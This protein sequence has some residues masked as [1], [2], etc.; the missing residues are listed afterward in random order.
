MKNRIAVSYH[1][2]TLGSIATSVI[3]AASFLVNAHAQTPKVQSRLELRSSDRQLVTAFNWAKQ[4]ALAYVHNG[5]PVGPWYEAA[6]PGRQAFCMR[7]VSH[8][9]A[10]AQA[11]GFAGYTHNMLRRFAENISSSRDW[12][13][14][15]EIDRLNRPAPIDYVNDDVFWY[16]LPANFDV[17]DACYRMYLW[18]GDTSYIDD[19][20]FLSFYRHT[21]TDYVSRWNLDLAHVMTRETVLRDTSYFRGDPSYAE[22]R[23]D[24][25]LG[26]DLLAAQYAGYRSYAAIAAIRG[27]A[28]TTKEYE[29][30]AADVKFLIN[31]KGWNPST[32]D[33]HGFLDNKHQF[34]GQAGA[35]LLYWDA[36]DDGLKARSA[37]D[38]LLKTMRA[39]PASAVEPES[40][41]AEILYRYGEPD[42][43]YAEIMDLTRTGR[44]RREYPE[45]SFS[46][47]GAIVNG[48]MGINVEPAVPIDSAAQSKHFETVISTLPQL[49][50][51]TAWA[52]LRNL[53]IGN[54]AIT[55]RHDGERRTTLINKGET[56]LN[57]EPAF[58]GAFASLVVNG[59]TI[60]A[61]T[62][63]RKFGRAITWIRVQV[64]AGKSARVEVP[65]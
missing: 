23:R 46:T 1:F 43:A 59:K 25:A 61:H 26:A 28:S 12:C 58:P 2:R 19:P 15:W 3:V 34:A 16:N 36:V 51:G 32:N 14:Y 5:D 52:E 13:S 37:L 42:A 39:E 53:P 41:Y 8:Q 11:L 49:T 10:G 21:V 4:Q 27:D 55:V 60:S 65:K 30:V 24:I 56:E 17:L 45:V 33:F 40:H 63:S 57:W 18:S 35:D 9:A 38:T 22:S 47:I 54:S 50:T 48:L 31:T 6:L 29:D 7:D 64:A 20:V 62:E 44:E